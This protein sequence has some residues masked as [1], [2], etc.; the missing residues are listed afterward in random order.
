MSSKVLSIF[1]FED[2]GSRFLDFFKIRD[3][4]VDEG[5]DVMDC[6][7]FLQNGKNYSLFLLGSH[8]APGEELKN[9][10]AR[11][12]S[13][14]NPGLPGWQCYSRMG[15]HLVTR[16]REAKPQTGIF[17]FDSGK[18]S[19]QEKIEFINAG[20]TEYISAKEYSPVKLSERLIREYGLLTS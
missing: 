1:N 10:D 18:I 15:V 5:F 8:V 20:A 3:I 12:Y 4:S 19:P 14:W 17:V 2:W 11:A 16:I 9:Q 13:V 6:L 7:D